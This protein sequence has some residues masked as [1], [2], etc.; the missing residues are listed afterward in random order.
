MSYQFEVHFLVRKG[1]GP[2]WVEKRIPIFMDD[3]D[4]EATEEDAKEMAI[5]EAKYYLLSRDCPAIKFIAI[6]NS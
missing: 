3:V 1:C 2:E 6:Y 4:P 5:D